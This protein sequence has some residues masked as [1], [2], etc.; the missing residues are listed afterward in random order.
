MADGPL[1]VVILAAGKGVRMRSALPKVLHAIGGRSMLAHALAGAAAA[2]AQRIAVVVGPGMEPLRAEALRVAPASEIFEQSEQLGTAHAV[3]AA[4]AALERHA[5]TVLVVFADS[6]LVEPAT[7]R[8]MIGALDG[9]A[10]IAVLGFEPADPSGYGR[11]IVD[12]WGRVAAIREEKDA[13]EAERR[14]RLCNAGAMAFRVPKL[15]D[16]LGRI[17]NDNA[18]AEY[19]L[20]DAPAL[21]AAS[22]LSALPVI[23]SA[24]EAQGINSRAQLAAAEAVFQRRARGRAMD[25][26]ATLIAPETVWFSYDTVLGSDVLVEPNVF[27]GPGVVVEDGAHILA[28]SHIV[29]ACI[30]AGARVG[31]FAR[32]RRGADIGPDVHVGNFVEVKNARLETGAKANHLAYIGDGRVGAGAN[33]GAGAIFCNYD[34]IDKHV[35][36]VGKG[37]FVGSNS[38]LVAPVKIG[39]GAY[40]GSGSVI[41][42]D[43]EA[44]ALAVERSTQDVR[45]G[46]AARFRRRKQK[47]RKGP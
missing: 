47:P 24:E 23:C 14:L 25:G 15:A 28:N 32:L 33:I 4:R 30:R 42:R 35:T 21:A 11:L 45:P 5:G 6:P 36:D 43:V 10:D 7:L 1:L 17:G 13:S 20:T 26:G 18:K 9:G 40:V 29:G 41:T 46:W 19:Y 38:S 31:P 16:L 22:G 27:F 37:A 12:E 3:L 34:G 44:D 39:D 2:G 8:R